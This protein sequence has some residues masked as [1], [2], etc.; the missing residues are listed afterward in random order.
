MRAPYHPI[1]DYLDGLKWD[2]KE[3][4]ERFAADYLG[5]DGH[6]VPQ[7][8]RQDCI[9]LGRGAHD[10][11]GCKADTMP[12]LE[13][14]QG[15]FKSTALGGA[16]LASWFSDDIAEL[17]SKDAAMQT[18]VAWCIEVAE[19]S[20]M[21]KGEVEKVKAFVSRRVDRYRP[22]YGR[23]VIEQPR[24]CI[25]VGTTNASVYLKD[26]TGARRYLPIR[27]GTIDLA[28]IKRDRDQL[29]AEAVQQYRN[30]TPWWLVD[31]SVIETAR[32]SRRP[33]TSRTSGARSSP[34]MWRTRTSRPSQR[35][36]STPCSSTR[37]SGIGPARCARASASPP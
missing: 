17:G 20:S 23:N 8:R 1:R 4:L 22:S 2:G 24:C 31:T 13:G 28:A 19:L 30:G 5:A 9:G 36:W 3:R 32:R 10:R 18:R 25:F 11:A 35:C 27:C 34:T 37:R 16:V 14:G 12:I 26:E 15:T 21:H 6:R 29:W 7:R 33:A